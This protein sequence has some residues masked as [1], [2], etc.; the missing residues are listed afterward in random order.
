MKSVLNFCKV[1]FALKWFLFGSLKYGYGDFS[2]FVNYLPFRFY[3][4]LTAE[5]QQSRPHTLPGVALRV[6]RGHDSYICE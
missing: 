6:E 1:N 5:I 3:R 4:N 2:D